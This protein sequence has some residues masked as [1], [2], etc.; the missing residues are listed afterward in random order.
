[1]NIR[2]LSNDEIA[3]TLVALCYIGRGD[4]FKEIN[5]KDFLDTI[6]NNLTNISE[7]KLKIILNEL[8][9]HNF[10]K[11]IS[12]TTITVTRRGFYYV[13]EILD[14]RPNNFHMLRYDESKDLAIRII[15]HF[16][17]H[18]K[19]LVTENE[20]AELSGNRAIVSQQVIEIMKEMDLL[21]PL[22][23]TADYEITPEAISVAIINREKFEQ[24]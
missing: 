6:R 9:N 3:K 2:L 18:Q 17:L 4:I 22:V 12:D 24:F 14:K 21:R 8:N 5:V 13:S 16:I 10:I 23:N 20:I 19:K 11:Y 1:M 7:N 15:Q